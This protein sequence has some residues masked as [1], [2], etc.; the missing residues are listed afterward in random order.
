MGTGTISNPVIAIVFLIL[1]F[2]NTERLAL[3]GFFI[4]V[5]LW[6]QE[7]GVRKT[8]LRV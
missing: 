1:F 8:I 6:M 7:E 2:K 4:M 5:A 3:I